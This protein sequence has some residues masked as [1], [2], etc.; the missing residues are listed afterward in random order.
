[1][2]Q[3]LV[4]NWQQCVSD[5]GCHEALGCH[6]QRGLDETQHYFAGN[7][8]WCRA[9]F[10]ATI[11]SMFQRECIKRYGIKSVESRYE[12]E[13]VIGNGPRLPI[14]RDYANHSVGHCP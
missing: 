3:H 8:Y 5:L 9:A 7:F 2:M 11:P 13:V 12:A 10:F 4:L 1:M 14:I 6:W